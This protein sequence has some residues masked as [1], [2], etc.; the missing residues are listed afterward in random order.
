MILAALL[1]TAAVTLGLMADPPADGLTL[2]A[3]ALAV[4]AGA[5]LILTLPTDSDRRQQRQ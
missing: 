4:A 5:R 1:A 2:A 3:V